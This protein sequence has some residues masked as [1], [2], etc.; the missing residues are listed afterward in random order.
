MILNALTGGDFRTFAI[1]LLL[2]L[3]VVIIALP[4]HE[5]AHGFVASKLGDPTAK[6]A[7][8][9]SLNPA[10]HLDP[11]GFLCMLF[12]GFGWAKPVPINTRNFRNPKRGMAITAAA[13][14]ISNF[15]LGLFST[16]MLGLVAAWSTYL[17]IYHSD[18]ALLIRIVEYL[19]T[20]FHL[21][22]LLNF[23]FMAF[24][25]IPIPPFD[26]S[27]IAFAFLP[28]KYYFAVMRY[29]RQ[30]MFGFLIALFALS[31]FVDF[32]PTHWIATKLTGWIYTP[33]YKFFSSLFLPDEIFGM[34][35]R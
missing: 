6:N 19:F 25:M 3:P 20:L 27:R 2:A 30:I 10:K 8:R 4:F 26:G 9:L 17:A 22:A 29:E 7:G 24:N 11:I 34:L 32:S 1:S 31:Y 14:P 21:S 5:T 12:F 28:P 13:G 15:I 16:V 18:N 33:C 35:F 23:M